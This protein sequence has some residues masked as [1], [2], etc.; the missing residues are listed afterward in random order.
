[1][2]NGKLLSGLGLQ[3]RNIYKIR[4]LGKMRVGNGTI[5][6][7]RKNSFVALAEKPVCENCYSKRTASAGSTSAALWAGYQLA[8][9]HK[10]KLPANT[11][12]T[13]SASIL[14]G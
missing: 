9:R 7:L 3:I 11:M 14:T 12:L 8:A 5:K 2:F 1:M 6:H 10:S 13:S 4:P